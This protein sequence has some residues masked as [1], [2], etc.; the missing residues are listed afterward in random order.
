MKRTV[1]IVWEGEIDEVR[2]NTEGKVDQAIGYLTMWG[3]D[4]PAYQ[5]VRIY[6]S[7]RDYEISASYTREPHEPR[8]SKA[9]PSFLLVGIWRTDEKKYGFYS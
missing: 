4:S 6:I 8:P 2:K 5:H 3:L 7:V 1:E 9:Q